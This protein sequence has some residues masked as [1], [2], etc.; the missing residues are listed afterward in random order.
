M[1]TLETERLTLR[2]WKR[3]DWKDAHEYAKDPEVSKY[4]MWGPN[5]E[6]ETKDFIDMAVELALVKPRRGYE[7]AIHLHEANKIIGGCGMQIAQNG[8][9]AMIG[10]TLHRDHWGKGIGTEAAR[11]LMFFGFEELGM[12]RMYATCDVD[13]QGSAHILEKLGM[14]REAHFVEDCMIHGKWRDTYLYAILAREWVL[15]T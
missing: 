15:R 9:S 7:L 11:R 3:S 2:D 1:F 12:H 13:N 10:Y 5:T 14:R 6:R 8:L 4:M